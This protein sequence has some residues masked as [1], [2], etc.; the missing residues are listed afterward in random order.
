MTGATVESRNLE[1]GVLAPA[2]TGVPDFI[3][4]YGGD[5]DRIFGRA[6]I[7]PNCLG[8]PT[9][10]LSLKSYCGL[11]EEA[12]RQTQHDNFGLWFGYQFVPSNL[13]LLGYVAI[14]SATMRAALENF[15]ALFPFH[16]QG[17]EMQLR[18]RDGLYSLE[19]RIHDAQILERRQDAE[20]S[21]GMFC[22]IFRHCY[23]SGWVPEEIHFEHPKPAEWKEHEQAF[24]AP[25]FFGQR[26]NAILFRAED[27]AG[28]M[29]NADQRL[30]A[31]LRTCLT[32]MGPAVRRS[33][34]LVD[35]LR[36]ELRRMLPDGYP[37]LEK[38]AET[39]GMA[40]WTVQRRLTEEGLTY[41]QLVEDTRK[42]LALMYLRQ[43]HIPLSE[44]A[45]LLGYSE[46]SAFSRAF[47]RWTGLSPRDYRNLAR[48]T[49]PEL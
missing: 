27:L 18:R 21:L 34:S 44:L 31:I 25:V 17:T 32:E 3:Q 8:N 33:E 36:S 24:Q 35:R 6:G 38:V 39:L 19:Y 28:R 26:T 42:E 20:L 1:P 40:V 47:R 10:N 37:S 7:D 12:A 23:G 45:F 41:K 22:N 5:P 49:P 11:F 2:A 15:V 29:P 30:L 16:Q 48:E 43:N 14:H 13:G 46:L 4:R 9:L